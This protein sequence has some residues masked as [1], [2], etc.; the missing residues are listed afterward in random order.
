MIVFPP[1]ADPD[2]DVRPA[3]TPAGTRHYPDSGASL[4]GAFWS[5]SAM[6]ELRAPEITEAEARGILGA[7]FPE[8]TN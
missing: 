3:T 1:D 6:A 7:H 8:A 5:L 4:M 2:G